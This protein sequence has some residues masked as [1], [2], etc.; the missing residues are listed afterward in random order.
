MS[1][2]ELMKVVISLPCSTRR[3]KTANFAQ[4]H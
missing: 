4:N 2:Q 3:P 1:S